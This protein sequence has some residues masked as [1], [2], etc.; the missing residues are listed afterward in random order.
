MLEP[1]AG[2]G[3]LL[4]S[5]AWTLEWKTSSSALRPSRKKLSFT[6]A[7]PAPLPLLE[8]LGELLLPLGRLCRGSRTLEL[9]PLLRSPTFTFDFVIRFLVCGEGSCDGFWSPLLPGA[10]ELRRGC[11]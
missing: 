5:F 9:W 6:L 11:F 10:E 8:V 7:K 4:G 3:Y 2:R 1:S